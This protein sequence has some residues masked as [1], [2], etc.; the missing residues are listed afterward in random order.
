MET[1]A[2]LTRRA[3]AR[4]QRVSTMKLKKKAG[5][6]RRLRRTHNPEFKARVALAA[7]REDKTLA[8]LCQEFDLHAN[9]ITEWKRQL[10]ERASAAFD[11]GAVE[12]EVDLTP[13][14]AKI[15]S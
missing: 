12:P 14:Q 2:I 3:Q 5:V 8:Q 7:L 6:A 11:G 4:L 15:G 1:Q 9:Q 10:I 13:L